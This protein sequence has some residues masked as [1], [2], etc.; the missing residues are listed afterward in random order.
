MALLLTF[1]SGLFFLV[2]IIAYH[3]A[4]HKKEIAV[5][6]I[7]TAAVVIIG[8]IVGDLVPELIEINKW[9]VI[10]FVLLGLIILMMMDKLIPHHHHDHHENDEEESEH[11][12]HLKHI[13]IITILALLLHNIIEGMALYSV[14][15]TNLKSGVLM[16]LGI[17]LHNLPFGFQIATYSKDKKS[18]FLIVLL[19]LSGFVGGL[20]FSIFG[21]FNATFEGIIIGIT[22][23]MILHILIFELLKEVLSNIKK[24]E[25]IYG[26]IIGII[27][28]IMINLI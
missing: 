11:Q 20:L 17:G 10:L 2:G 1:C 18:I 6:S 12:G 8:L 27:L 16:L 28:L 15:V 25:T 23:G 13:G 14:A 21:E 7:A 3:F 4:S 19:V 26:I 5:A 24:K 22:L 9:W